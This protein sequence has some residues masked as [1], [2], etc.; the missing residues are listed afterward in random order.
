MGWWPCA[1]GMGG[2]CVGCA[3]EDAQAMPAL[4]GLE[5]ARGLPRALGSDGLSETPCLLDAA[6]YLH[7]LEQ[8]LYTKVAFSGSCYGTQ[9]RQT[10]FVWEKSLE[11]IRPTKARVSQAA[12]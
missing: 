11:A 3:C 2:A 10:D 7:I 4:H 5:F 6:S 1:E 8:G 12:T 9:L